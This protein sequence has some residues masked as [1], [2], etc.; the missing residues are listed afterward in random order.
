M[1][2]TSAG[3]TERASLWGGLNKTVQLEPRIGLTPCTP[4]NVHG[5]ASVAFPDSR[6]AEEGSVKQHRL[7][8]ETW[9]EQLPSER[10]PSV[11]AALE[12]AALRWAARKGQARSPIRC[13]QRRFTANTMPGR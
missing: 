7:Q 2:G 5:R 4:A 11:T 6:R 1:V 3:F 10:P 8:L 9:S 13:R 12:I